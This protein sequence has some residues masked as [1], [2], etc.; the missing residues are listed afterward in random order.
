MFKDSRLSALLT[1]S[2]KVK[3]VFLCP[4]PTLAAWARVLISVFVQVVVVYR[5]NFILGSFGQYHFQR[6]DHVS[7][8]TPRFA[9]KSG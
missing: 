6:H 1:L 2:N 7:K 8:T 4:N 3:L 5:F 9:G